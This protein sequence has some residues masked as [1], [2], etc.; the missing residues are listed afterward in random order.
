M[1]GIHSHKVISYFVKQEEVIANI[2]ACIF[3]IIVFMVMETSFSILIGVM[4]G[5][6]QMNMAVLCTFIGY[7][8]LA[9]PLAFFFAFYAQNLLNWQKV[10]LLDKVTGIVGLYVGTD[11][12]LFIL[13]ISILVE[14][15]SANWLEI[16]KSLSGD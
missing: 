15:L 8:C 9:L 5:L 12:A 3:P 10:H 4:K 16:G 2:R 13:N 11:M 6:G 1:F 14:I 7:Y